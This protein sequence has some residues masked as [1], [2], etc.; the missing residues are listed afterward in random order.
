MC[1]AFKRTRFPRTNSEFYIVTTWAL[2]KLT[3]IVSPVSI[4]PSNTKDS[5]R[6]VVFSL[7][8]Y[9]HVVDGGYSTFAV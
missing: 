7:T 6:A 9:V 3:V 5:F 8:V 1:V 2:T 4:A